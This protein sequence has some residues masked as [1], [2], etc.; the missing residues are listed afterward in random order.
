MLEQ[1][2]SVLILRVAEQLRVHAKRIL[3]KENLH[4]TS[5]KTHPRLDL[6]RTIRNSL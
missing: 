1:E 6:Q 3:V 2:I 4:I 5:D